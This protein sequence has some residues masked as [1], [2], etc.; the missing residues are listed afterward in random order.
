MVWLLDYKTYHYK[1]TKFTKI[2]EPKLA[3]MKYSV[4][5]AIF[6]VSPLI[7]WLQ[8]VMIGRPFAVM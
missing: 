7:N 2:Q 5:L 1:T 8:L 3:V 6:L 4:M